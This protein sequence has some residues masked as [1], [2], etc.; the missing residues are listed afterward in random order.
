MSGL[1]LIHIVG[2]NTSGLAHGIVWMLQTALKNPLTWTQDSFDVEY[3]GPDNFSLPSLSLSPSLPLYLMLS[4]LLLSPKWLHLVVISLLT[5][6]LV[7]TR[8]TYSSASGANPRH[9]EVLAM[10]PATKVPWP[11]WSSNVFS[12]VQSVRSFKRWKCGWLR[13]SP[14]SKTAT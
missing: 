12:S 10:T 7:N 9:S 1:R 14:V 5:W 11:R 2:L 8:N 6:L 13:A 4:N 3:D